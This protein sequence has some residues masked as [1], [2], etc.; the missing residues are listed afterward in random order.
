MDHTPALSGARRD[1]SLVRPSLAGACSGAGI[2]TARPIRRPCSKSSYAC[3][4]QSVCLHH[5]RDCTTRARLDLLDDGI[6]DTL[7]W[8][9]RG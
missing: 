1:E 6:G 7:V 5:G 8:V 3:L 2:S 4:A 9:A